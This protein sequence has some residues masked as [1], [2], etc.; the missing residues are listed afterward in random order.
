MQLTI[1]PIKEHIGATVYMPR[2]AI[3]KTGVAAQLL[4]ALERHTVLVFPALG[5]TDHEQL[6]LTDS[7]GQRVNFTTPVAGGDLALKDVYTVTLDPRINNESEYVL[8]TFF[9]HMDGLTSNIPPPRASLLA[10]RAL[11]P[12]GGQTEF[13]STAAA[14]QALPDEEKAELEGVRVIHTTVAS[15]REVATPDVLMPSKRAMQREHPLVWT[16]QDGRKFLLIGSTA[17]Y[18]IGMT[19]AESRALFARLLEWSAQPMFTYRHRWQEDDLV[20][21]DNTAAL[22]RV[23]PYAVDSGR[24][25]HRTSVAGVDALN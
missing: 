23:V 20:I 7:L 13:A 17:D 10:A 9:W 11:A 15:V 21:W 4:E 8:G 19:K 3:G 5:L 25:M 24:R 14:Y 2:D 1:D 12:K 6:A 18:A 16:R 22:H